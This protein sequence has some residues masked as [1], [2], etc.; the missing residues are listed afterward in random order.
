MHLRYISVTNKLFFN[1]RFFACGFPPIQALLC[2]QSLPER[3]THCKDT[4]KLG[5]K[6]RF[7]AETSCEF[8]AGEKRRMCGRK[9][10]DV[11][12]GWRLRRHG[13]WLGI[14]SFVC[15]GLRWRMQRASLA[16]A[17]GCVGGW[18]G[19]RWQ[20][21]RASLAVAAGPVG[22]WSGQHRLLRGTNEP[23]GSPER[24]EQT[25]PG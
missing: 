5:D 22:V 8:L 23:L 7:S 12:R 2:P 25:S 21:Q 14:G 16:V 11:R 20:L 4:K 13:F 19:L 15:S 10:A 6:E 24:A 9:L 3:F 18:S 1:L 17:A